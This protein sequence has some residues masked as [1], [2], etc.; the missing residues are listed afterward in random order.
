MGEQRAPRPALAGNRQ[1]PPVQRAVDW[2][3]VATA[4]PDG[5]AVVDASG[6]FTQLNH[7][8]VRLCGL[9]EE[10]LIGARAPFPLG[11][12]PATRTSGLLEED[13]SAEHVTSWPLGPG[14]RREF[15]YRLLRLPARP[16]LT[17]VAFRDVTGDRQRQRRVTAIARTAANL[18]TQGSLTATLD[19]LAAE[20]V[21]ADALAGVQILTLDSSGRS[22]QIMGA[23][24]FGHWPDFFDRLLQVRE[25]GGLLLMLKALASGETVVVPDRWAVTRDD[26]AWAPLHAYLGELEWE[27][28][29]SVPLTMRGRRTGVL[30]AFFKPGE[31]IGQQALEFLAAMAEQA[32]IAVD[33]AALL[34]RERDAARRDE[35]QRLARDLHDSIVQQVFSISMQA[36]SMAVLAQRDSTLPAEAVRRISDEVGLLSKAALDDLRAMVHELRPASTAELGG[37]EEAI[38]AL[39]ASTANRT[40]LRFR[41]SLGQDLERITGELAEDVYRIIAEAIHNVVKHAAAS[42]VTVRLVVS[43]DKLS[44]SVTDYGRGISVQSSRGGPADA[45]AGYGLKT[46]KERAERWRGTVTVRPRREGGTVVRLRVPLA[47]GVPLDSARPPGTRETSPA[48]GRQ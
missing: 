41:L 26:P 15:A 28:F 8:A 10:D 33:Y 13:A 39:S 44:A 40:G 16:G 12:D 5:L 43:G 37:L 18:A 30:N 2:S 36:E 27:S 17:V 48:T 42:Q 46:M 29:A 14:H 32:A 9:A 4:T 35:R 1:A 19:A 31:A 6:R 23:A 24:G 47:V 38:Q 7:A 3:E 21:Q 34:E 20:V 25:R 45:A 11:L 22:L